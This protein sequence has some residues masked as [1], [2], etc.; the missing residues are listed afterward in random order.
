MPSTTNRT[1]PLQTKSLDQ[2][3]QIHAQD[4]RDIDSTNNIDQIVR[5]ERNHNI[6]HRIHFIHIFRLFLLLFSERVQI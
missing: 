1:F 4:R 2:R 6:S 3:A 5:R